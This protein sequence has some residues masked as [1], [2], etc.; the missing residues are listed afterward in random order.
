MLRFKN[1]GRLR[2]AA[3]SNNKVKEARF[4]FETY[5]EYNE[6]LEEIRRMN[7]E[8]MEEEFARIT[9]EEQNSANKHLSDVFDI[10]EFAKRWGNKIFLIAGVGAGKS[11]WVIEVLSR[12]GSV[13]FVTSRRVK[14]DEDLK[15][16]VFEKRLNV[17]DR[18]RKYLNLVTNAELGYYV[19]KLCTD[20]KNEDNALIDKFINR[21]DYIVIDEVHS[22]AAD[23]TFAE[24]SFD[25]QAFMEYAANMGNV[26]VA[27]TGTPQPVSK[28]FRENGWCTID[29][30]K[31]CNYVKPLR[32]DKLIQKNVQ[33]KIFA[34]I[35]VGRKVIYFVNSVSQIP[36]LCKELTEINPKK[37]NQT[38][39]PRDIAVIVAKSRNEELHEQLEE[40]IKVGSK[41]I[42]KTSE[43]TY[44]SII[45]KQLIPEKC[46][47][48]ISTSTLREGVD[49]YNDN[50]S[51]ICDNHVLSNII[52]FCGRTR[53]ANSV[54]YVVIDKGQHIVDLNS[55][56]Y[57]YAC[58]NEVAAA[59]DFIQNNISGIVPDE[60]I[61]HVER[62]P[63]IRFNY[64][65]R[66]FQVNQMKYDE[67]IRVENSL[68]RW[69]E[70]L[71]SYCDEYEINSFFMTPA[72]KKKW[73]LHGLDNLVKQEIKIFDKEHQQALCEYLYVMLGLDRVYLQ[74]KKLNEQ[75]EKYGYKIISMTEKSGENRDK[76]YW[77]VVK[78]PKK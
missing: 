55:L 70:E 66:E 12:K 34:E 57:E 43:E 11:T 22:I 3:Q 72:Q 60:L 62:N 15:K 16:S 50:V 58:K 10:D 31:R 33:E 54:F 24:S 73:I 46:K 35:D 28:Y 48:L 42:I 8:S 75:L 71:K 59:N 77:K 36:K 7:R 21:Y 30:R 47:L 6:H 14:V 63:Y 18:L 26:V 17:N 4:K 29:L 61:M 49:I 25:V 44:T 51:V 2:A 67:Q 37:Q 41:L 78:I 32:I 76:T 69:E 20:E 56:M 74:P 65:L 52:Q 13:L 23:S 9:E 45:E 1:S 53:L 64:I 40:T 19:K 27:M 39:N 38:L 5:P 68:S